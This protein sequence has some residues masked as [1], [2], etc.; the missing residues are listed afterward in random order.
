[1]TA[2]NST[3]NSM[4]TAPTAIAAALLAA[5]TLTACGGGDG[6]DGGDGGGDGKTGAATA[7]S[8]KG[9][10]CT[11][12]Q[13][14]FE[15][16][17]SSA[18]PAAGDEGAVPVT[19]TNKGKAACTL[20]GL[21]GVDLFAGDKSWALKPQEGASEDTEATLEAGQSM[22]FTIAYVRGVAGDTEKSAVVDQLKLTLPGDS[23]VSSFKWPDAEV[24]VKS[25]STLEATVGPFLPAGD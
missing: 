4:R 24:A 13:A 17:P 11:A 21:A 6:S 2:T 22:T 9:G 12:A 20:T 14:G 19:V 23:K 3:G 16:G 5:L 1:M 25:E 10:A 7:D 8:G 18:A 15:V